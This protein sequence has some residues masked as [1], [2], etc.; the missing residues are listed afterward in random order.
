M[1]QL[2][3]T[4]NT[5]QGSTPKEVQQALERFATLY[6]RKRQ[7]KDQLDDINKE[8]NQL[9]EYLRSTFFEPNGL[10]SIRT[11]HGTVSIR[12]DIRVGT[13]EGVDRDE[14]AARLK[15]FK[16]FKYLVK[17]NYNSN[18][19]AAAVRERYRTAKDQ[20]GDKLLEMAPDARAKRLLELSVGKKLAEILVVHEQDSLTLTRR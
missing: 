2:D 15:R 16:A 13:A 9:D 17:P 7:V 19:L 1:P 20:L 8:M 4:H 10:R 14:A 3:P 12:T 5:T 11:D 18:S 6:E